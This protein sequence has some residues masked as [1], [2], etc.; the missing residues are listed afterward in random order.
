M[1]VGQT[2]RSLKKRWWEHCRGTQCRVL[3]RA[4][5]KYKSEN[6]IITPIVSVFMEKEADA[7]ETEYISFFDTMNPSKE[8]N[9]TSGGGRGRM[10]S[11][12]SRDKMSE[13]KKGE[14]NPHR[15]L[16]NNSQKYRMNWKENMKKAIHG[17]PHWDWTGKS[18][19]AISRYLRVHFGEPNKCENVHCIYPRKIGKKGKLL[20]KP[21]GYKWINITDNNLSK[22]RDAWR[23]LCNSCAS[24]WKWNG[25]GNKSEVCFA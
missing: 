7:L 16:M 6:F 22:T 18:P 2:Y 25:F 15:N 9:L 12:E 3:G 21:T 13:S 23:I 8:Y 10:L 19:A 11:N 17:H 5:R 4:I 20:Q 14:A 1:Y 24:F